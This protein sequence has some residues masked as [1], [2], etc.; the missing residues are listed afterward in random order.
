MPF[1][2]FT[3]TLPVLLRRLAAEHGPRELIV[4]EAGRRMSY[5]HRV[6]CSKLDAA[7]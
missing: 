7:Q 3:P 4:T 6:V 2:D 1:P 5:A